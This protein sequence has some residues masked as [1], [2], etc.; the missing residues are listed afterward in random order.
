MRDQEINAHCSE[1]NARNV[2]KLITSPSYV[3]KS[4]VGENAEKN[5]FIVS[6]T[7]KLRWIQA[8]KSIASRFH[9]KTWKNKV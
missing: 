1:R 2:A 7:P 8:T 3:N 9:S 4:L 6:K 5:G